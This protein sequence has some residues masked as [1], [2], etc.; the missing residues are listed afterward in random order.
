MAL[1]SS[2]IEDVRAHLDDVLGSVPP[3][4]ANRLRIEIG[5]A[6]SLILECSNLFI[7]TPAER[8]VALALLEQIESFV[9]ASHTASLTEESRRSEEAEMEVP[10]AHP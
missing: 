10:N 1:P 8:R 3:H 2:V 6:G 5:L 7:M 9:A 4:R